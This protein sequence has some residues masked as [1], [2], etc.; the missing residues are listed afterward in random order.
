MSDI[1]TIAL[2]VAV[3]IVLFVW[4]RLPVVLV[5]MAVGLSLWA[6][7]ILSLPQAL[8]GYGDPAVLFIAALFVVSAAL[9]RTGITAWAGQALI[10]GAGED[11]RARLLVLSARLRSHRAGSRLRLGWARRWSIRRIAA[12]VTIASET[13]V[14]AS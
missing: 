2:I 7:G 10:A 14:S 4:N 1:T 12:R 6:T 9:D 8:A 11:S 3:A 13:S 5:A